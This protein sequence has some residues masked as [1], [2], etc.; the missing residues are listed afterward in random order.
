MLFRREWLWVAVVLIVLSAKMVIS[1]ERVTVEKGCYPGTGVAVIWQT[2]IRFTSSYR[3]LPV[4]R[5]E[6][7]DQ[8]VVIRSRLNEG[9][10][11]IQTTIGWIDASK[12]MP[13][14]V[15][16]PTPEPT[17]IPMPEFL[18]LRITGDDQFVSEIR[19]GFAFLWKHSPYW[20]WYV[21][22]S[23]ILVIAPSIGHQDSRAYGFEKR[24][25]I[26]EWYMQSITILAS[27]LV[28]EA[29]HLIQF[30]EGRWPYEGDVLGIIQAERECLA[31]EV[32]MMTE[33]RPTHR[34]RHYRTMMLERTVADWIASGDLSA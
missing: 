2:P 28:H 10:C 9:I 15:P 4:A 17:P 18:I 26:D 16:T 7:S 34:Y 33:I 19:K 32:G 23:G 20:Y 5:A 13:A 1:Q 21:V 22:D 6:P 30:Q 27:T 29:C 8:F 3:S 14:F 24:I 25:E 31:L 12:T 11:W